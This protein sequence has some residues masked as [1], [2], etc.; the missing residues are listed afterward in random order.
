LHRKDRELNQKG[1]RKTIDTGTKPRNPT[2]LLLE[3][4]AEILSGFRSNLAV[5][6]GPENAAVEDLAPVTHDQSVALQLNQLEF[7]QLKMI[8][9]ALHRIRSGEYGLCSE[10][11]EPIAPRRLEILPWAVRCV[12]CEED[13]VAALADSADDDQEAA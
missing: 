2:G 8:D 4:K 11:E 13:Y 7:L 1:I 6:I 9:A 10:C 5:F 12:T 3:R